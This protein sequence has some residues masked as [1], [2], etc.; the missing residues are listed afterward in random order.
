MQSSS[1][2]SYY[3][4]QQIMGKRTLLIMT[5]TIAAIITTSVLAFALPKH[6]FAQSSMQIFVRNG[7]GLGQTIA[8]HE[9]QAGE[10][11]AGHEHAKL[12]ESQV[13]SFVLRQFDH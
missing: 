6:V 9:T 11:L 12:G 5:A 1:N 7:M 13:M 3:Y 4:K 10:V 8:G 2:S